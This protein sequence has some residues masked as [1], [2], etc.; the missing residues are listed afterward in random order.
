LSSRHRPVAYA[1]SFASDGFGQG[2]S[3]SMAVK[4]QVSDTDLPANDVT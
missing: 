1:A 4:L 2:A 3:D